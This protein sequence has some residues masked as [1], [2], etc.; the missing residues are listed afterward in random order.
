MSLLTFC[1]TSLNAQQTE[2]VLSRKSPASLDSLLHMDANYSRP[3]LQLGSTPVSIGGYFEANT[4][5]EVDEGDTEGLAF[6]MRRLAFVVASP[7]TKHLNFMTEIEFEDQGREV[8]L[9]YAALDL[10]L[11]TELNFRGGLIINPI[12][13]FN[14]NHDGPKWEF[15]ERPMQAAKLL[16]ATFRNVGFGIYGKTYKKNWV[17]GYEA[18]L[19]NGFNDLIIN[20]PKRRTYLPATKGK[21]I[22]RASV[23]HDESQESDFENFSGLPMFTGKLALK[24]RRIGEIGLSYMGGIYNKAADDEGLELDTKNR[25]VDVLALDLSTE[26]KASKTSL[27]GEIAYIW[28]DVPDTYTQLYG[29]QQWGTFLDIVQTIMTRKVL[30]WDAATLNIAA[31]LDYVDYNVGTFRETDE[32]IGDHVLA[33]TPAISF[34]PTDQTVFRLNYRYAMETD[35]L[36]NPAELSATWYFGFSTYF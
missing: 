35:E 19:T 22:G 14:Q 33:I 25:R 30:S 17:L 7:I 11:Y 34:R 15:V 32:N 2:E 18:Y 24:N 6:Q 4:F 10:N 3:T 36:R 16:P 20:N 1:F 13:S 21:P 29:N 8:S 31:R 27:R 9:E 12:G 23:S 26:I 28:V 5:Y